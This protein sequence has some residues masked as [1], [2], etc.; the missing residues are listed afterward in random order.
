ML[1]EKKGAHAGDINCVRWNPKE[2]DLLA[3]CGDD[4]MVRI[5]RVAQVEPPTNKE[6]ANGQSV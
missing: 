6:S 2:P 3:S 4:N 1:C 5:W